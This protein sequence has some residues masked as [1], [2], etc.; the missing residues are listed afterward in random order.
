MASPDFIAWRDSTN[1]TDIL[2]SKSGA[3]SGNYPADTIQTT[4]G[5]GAPYFTALSTTAATAGLLRLQTGDTLCW[6]NN[7]NGANACLSKNASDN[8]V[9]PNNLGVASL[10]ASA[11]VTA[12][13]SVTTATFISSATNPST[14]GTIRLAKSDSVKARNATNGLDLTVISIDGS[15]NVLLGD[16]N[17]GHIFVM[18]TSTSTALTLSPTAVAGKADAAFNLIA[19]S[20]VSNAGRDINLIGS[21]ALASAFDGG[22]ANVT[23]GNGGATG[24]GGSITLT[25]GTGGVANGSI[26]LQ[27]G[28]ST[29]GSGYKH[30]NVTTGSISGT[31]RAEVTITWGTAFADTSYDPTC[32]VQDG[33]SGATA[34]GL[35]M[36][37]IRQK[38]A[39]IVTAVVNN[40][41]GGALTGTLY[42]TGTHN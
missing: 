11:T 14:T 33:T 40:P 24:T 4:T 5:F 6:R 21:S 13:T 36:E 17:V 31:T 15:D 28:V 42:C 12:T 23:A 25:P 22:A 39:S 16:G 35:V 29:N 7:A 1:A 8:L 3:L 41:T 32:S 9:W 20:V 26:K 19:Q 18:G 27:V 30:A 37:R 38:T 2:L 34:A 10:T